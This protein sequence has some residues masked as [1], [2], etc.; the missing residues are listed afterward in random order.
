MPHTKQ[1]KEAQKTA[2]Y[3]GFTP[4]I[5]LIV[6]KQDHG[7]AK[8]FKDSKREVAKHDGLAFDY[9]LEEKIAIIR[10]FIE[11]KMAHLSVPAMIHHNG[12]ISGNPH[13]QIAKERLFNLDIIG[14]GKSIAEAIIIETSHVI[15]R[16][17]YPELDLMI[18]I[19]SI[20]DKD[21][22]AKFT[23]ELVQYYKKH[24]NDLPASCRALFKK[25][26][27]A[28]LSCDH[29]KCIALQDEAPKA[30]GYL[31]EPSREHFRE[32][33]EFIESLNLPYI[34]NHSLI[35]SQHYCSGTIFRIIGTSK[36][37]KTR[38]VLVIGER[39]NTVARKAWGKKEVPAIGASITIDHD[40][41]E[42]EAPSKAGSKSQKG[43]KD[44]YGHVDKAA[45]GD[46]KAAKDAD[47]GLSKAEKKLKEETPKFYFIQLGYDAKLKSLAIIEML[48]KAHI[49]VLQS[50]SRD[51]ITSQLAAAEK[52][53]VPYILL[54]GQKEA[55]ENSVTVRSTK[56]HAQETVPMDQLV[57]YLKKL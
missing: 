23:R 13:K 4:F 30:M 47:K 55:I 15:A 54:V 20:G 33:L 34:I 37:G 22:M 27:F 14:N 45:K 9:F 32:V 24:L 35:G 18:E 57:A 50:L 10:N 41:A 51:K 2:M 46:K 17:H 21:S 38:R 43:I 29:E 42:T 26:P 52:M 44:K 11:K 31:S 56:N 12:P 48:R 8:H 3:Y 28:L 39:Y 25:D 16:E 36:D 7:K 40:L 1:H 5:E 49:P 53:G 6:E 19:N